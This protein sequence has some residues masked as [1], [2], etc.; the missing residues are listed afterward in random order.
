M[1]IVS[2]GHITIADI[3]DSPSA[4]LSNESSVAPSNTDGSSPVLTGCVTTLSIFLGGVDDSTNW[5]VAATPSSGVTGTLATRTYTVTG[6]TVDAGWVDLTATRVGWPS[7]TKRFSLSKGKQGVAGAAGAT[8]AAGTNGTNGTNGVNGTNG[9]NFAEAKLL[10]TDPTFQTSVNG[11]GVYNNSGGGTV[12]ITGVA[13]LSDSPFT[14]SSYSVEIANTGVAS[15]G[16]GGFIHYFNTRANAVFVQRIVAKLPVGYSLADQSNAMG[17][18]AT[19]TWIT[20]TTG[21]GRFQEYILVRRCGATGT[22]SNTGYINAQGA[23]GTPAVPVKWWLAYAAVYDFTALGFSSVVGLLSNDAHTVPTDSAGNGGNFTG[24]ATTLTLFNGSADDSANWAVTASPTNV[25]GT[26][27]GKTYTVTALSADTGYVDLTATRGGFSNVVKRFTLMKSKAGTAGATGATGSTGATGATG[28]VGP[29]GPAVTVTP[30]RAPTFTN[31]D[32]VLDGGQADIVFTA[33]V[34]GVTS[35]TYVWTFS[36]LQTNPTASATAS[37]TV[38]AAQFGTSRSAIVTCTVSGTHTDKVAIVRLDQSTAA[39]NA[40]NTSIDANGNIQGVSS[41]S[42]Q[43]VANNTNTFI[44]APGG[45]QYLNGAPTVTGAL[46]IV[47]PVGNANPSMPLMYVDIYEYSAGL[48]CTLQLSGHNWTGGTWHNVTAFVVGASNVEYPVRFGFTAGGKHCIYIGELTETWAYPQ[49]RVRD[50]TIG[51]A[52]QNRSVWEAGWVVDFV[53]AAFEGV[54]QTVLDTKP[55]ADWSKSTRRPANLAALTGTEAVQNSLV[56]PLLAG[57]GNSLVPDYALSDVNLWESIGGAGY[58]F[59][60]ANFGTVGDGKVGRNVF[61]RIHPTASGCWNYS[62]SVVPLVSGR[63]YVGEFWGRSASGTA[64]SWYVSALHL[65]ADGTIN[66]ADTSGYSYSTVTTPGTSWTLL[67]SGTT[68]SAAWVAARLAAG[69]VAIRPGFALAH[70]Y[71]LPAGGWAEA[72]G[73]RFMDTTV[74]A[75]TN[76]ALSTLADIASDSKLAPDEKH[77]IRQAWDVAITEK[78]GLNTEASRYSLASTANAT[79]NGAIQALGTYLNGGTAYTLSTTV[80]PTWIN[81][82]SLQTTTDISGAT[83]RNN[84]KDFYTSRQGLVNKLTEEAGKVASWSGVSGTGK[85]L[86]NAGNVLDT[87]AVN[88][89]PNTYGVGNHREFKTCSVVGITTG[90]NYCVVET[91]KG[92]VDSSG[93]EAV[94]WAYVTSG[95]VWKRSAGASATSWGAWVRD[96]DRALYT[97]DLAANQTSIDANGNIQ[98]VSS[99]AGQSVANNV[100]SV[101]RAPVG[102]VLNTDAPSI[103][104]AIKIKLPQLWSS[105]MLKFT[106]EI[107]EYLAGYSCTLEIAGY[108]YSG[109][110]WF[111]CTARVIGGSNVEYPVRF[112][113]DADKNCVWIGNAGETWAYPQVLVRDVLMGYSNYSAAQ[114]ATGWA[115]S[116]DTTTLTSGTAA[117]QYNVEVLDTL[118]GAD[119]SKVRGRPSGALMSIDK[120]T[121]A[122]I[123][124]VMDPAAVGT[125][126]I[127]SGAVTSTQVLTVVNN[128]GFVQ[129]T[130]GDILG[131]YATPQYALTVAVGALAVGDAVLV[132][133]SNTSASN[134]GGSAGILRLKPGSGAASQFSDMG[135]LSGGKA[136]VAGFTVASASAANDVQIVAIYDRPAGGTS[137]THLVSVQ[138][139]RR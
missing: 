52:A 139:I 30:N 72:Q 32:N 91:I 129:L 108:N 26:L 75:A 33:A 64:G 100:N 20:P 122:N 58:E 119:W 109:V 83:F 102:G 68:F 106:V 124:T 19:N 2:T 99:G 87:R 1:P 136:N 14:D 132:T 94:Q 79:Y 117:N 111:N 44:R 39:A 17:D 18:G 97:G 42:G 11:I 27:S 98:G 28:A 86:D 107:Y 61:R 135:P 134:Y 13:R 35:P 85:P 29:Q 123:G 70:S 89:A 48:A 130:G 12:T 125:T 37:Q 56:F 73:F 23:A 84:W 114:W 104:G 80:P 10:Y 77:G 110:G 46:R 69:T 9:L 96:L 81:D 63:T 137:L 45:G 74:E 101:I 5:T 92:W 62:R 78:A 59:S 34:S 60:S 31:T 49:V 6:F 88:G 43:S 71:T 76:T 131:G 7:L 116:F 53:T 47:L 36:G 127:A 133:F 82:A 112:G 65:K 4:V 21:T 16:I 113:R 24:A 22:F 38:T 103:T 95:E 57:A 128:T 55:G 25:T 67:S 40:N 118:P 15:P 8:G 3:N 54:T 51:Y 105:T 41:G 121:P 90:S 50:V 93:G 66:T 126:Q 138:V 115:I 120:F